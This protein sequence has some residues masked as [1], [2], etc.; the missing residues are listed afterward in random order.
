MNGISKD[1]IQCNYSHLETVVQSMNTY[2]SDSDFSHLLNVFSKKFSILKLQSIVIGCK[3]N[4]PGI[5]VFMPFR[6][7]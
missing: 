1:A 5:I 3:L 6:G 4:I 7:S 2:P